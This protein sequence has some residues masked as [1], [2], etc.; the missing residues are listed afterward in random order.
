MKAQVNE[1]FVQKMHEDINAEALDGDGSR[2]FLRM[3]SRYVEGHW[4]RFVPKIEIFTKPLKGAVFVD[5]GSKFGHLT[6]LLVDQGVEKIFAVDVNDEYLSQGKRFFGSRF[7]VQYVKSRDCY[8]D[9][10]SSSVDLVLANEMISHINPAF[11]DTFYAEVARILKPGGEL[12]ISDGNNW[13]HL[14]TRLDLLE[15]CTKWENGQSKEFGE[16]NYNSI[17]K[18]MI[19]EQYPDIDAAD[20]DYL[21]KNTSGLFGDR[22]M[23]QVERYLAGDVFI[24]RPHRPGVYPTHPRFGVVMERAFDP[25]QVLIS[26]ETYGVDAVQVM[27]GEQLRD[28]ARRGS[29]K[30]F[31]IRGQKMPET[32]E[33]L[34]DHARQA[35]AKGAEVNVPRRKS[36]YTRLIRRARR[37]TANRQKS[38][39]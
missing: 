2:N 39:A 16:N 34:S 9:I 8:V 3:S 28:D 4:K 17:R 14:K 10:Q 1:A 30:N 29:T 18:D 20:L 23:E 6:P 27:R 19:L 26:L 22:L 31:T 38:S 36:L 21:A 11:L 13:S 37:L 33:A 24:E 5:Y 7:P 35:L 12:V 32:I 25:R 15:W